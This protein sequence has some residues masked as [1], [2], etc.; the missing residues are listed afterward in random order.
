M[1]EIT[2]HSQMTFFDALRME[3][4]S[5][6]CP[7]LA[8]ERLKLKQMKESRDLNKSFPEALREPILRR[9]QFSTVSR[10]DNLGTL[11]KVRWVNQDRLTLHSLQWTKY[12]M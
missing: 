5:E 12:M 10:L 1:C 3:V 11:V 4:C 6:C 8:G 7:C 9:I 2:G